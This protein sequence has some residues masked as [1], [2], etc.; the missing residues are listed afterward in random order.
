MFSSLFLNSEG[1]GQ[2]LTPA[3]RVPQ[4]NGSYS[5][6]DLLVFCS[7]AVTKNVLQSIQRAFTMLPYSQVSLSRLEEEVPS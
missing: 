6:D 4:G 1:T 2:Y 3:Q 5:A 7:K